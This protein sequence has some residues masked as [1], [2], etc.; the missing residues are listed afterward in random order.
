MAFSAQRVLMGELK[1]QFIYVTEDNWTFIST[2]YFGLAVDPNRHF[3]APSDKGSRTPTTLKGETVITLMYSQLGAF[4]DQFRV[5][6]DGDT[7]DQDFFIAV[8]PQDG[9]RFLSADADGFAQVSN[10]TTWVF[11]LAGGPGSKPSRWDGS[12]IST[13]VFEF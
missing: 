2:D 1:V 4:D 11:D 6:I 7:H 13:V 9:D 5:E 12:G 10:K 8:T 3:S